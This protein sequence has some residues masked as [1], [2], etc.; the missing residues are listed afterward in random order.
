M[1][2]NELT[3]AVAGALLAAFLLGWV[4]HW[5]FARMHAHGPRN[6]ARTADI[7]ARLHAAEAARDQAT[8]AVAEAEAVAAHR[9]AGL[10]ADL[11]AS[12]TAVSHAESQAEEIRAAYREALISRGTP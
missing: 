11:A 2:R 5:F 12:R 4:T 10:E 1:D 7:A 9:I 3:L 6:A 8:R